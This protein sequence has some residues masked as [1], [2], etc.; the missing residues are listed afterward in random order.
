MLFLC[1]NGN[2]KDM[3]NMCRKNDYISDSF[4]YLIVITCFYVIKHSDR[5][6]PVIFIIVECIHSACL[7]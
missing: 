4:L 3:E 6:S 1:T 7:F 5:T 2:W